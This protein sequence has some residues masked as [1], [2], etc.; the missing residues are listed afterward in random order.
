MFF[1]G[2][3]GERHLSARMPQRLL[4]RRAPLP[5]GER[6]RLFTRQRPILTRPIWKGPAHAK[7][8][9]TQRGQQAISRDRYREGEAPP[10]RD[11]P[12]GVATLDEAETQTPWDRCPLGNRDAAHLARLAERIVIVA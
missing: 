7:T 10:Q 8:K 12:L 5:C 4:S 3:L 1:E 9:D 6:G 11:E 2:V